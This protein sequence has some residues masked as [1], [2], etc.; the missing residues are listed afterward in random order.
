MSWRPGGRRGVEGGGGGDGKDVWVVK[1][2]RRAR[3]GYTARHA[4][5]YILLPACRVLYFTFLTLY[6]RPSIPI[7][8]ASCIVNL[9]LESAPKLIFSSAAPR[10][11]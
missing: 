7:E 5:L 6:I 2:H 11:A 4:T 8:I 10:G 3:W 9:E 1:L